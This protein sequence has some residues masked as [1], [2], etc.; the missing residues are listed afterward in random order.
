MKIPDG[1]IVTS[2]AVK[3][4]ASIAS[5]KTTVIVLVSVALMRPG[6]RLLD[7]VVEINEYIYVLVQSSRYFI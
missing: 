1:V 3:L 2:E 5:L 7:I 4:L 6:L